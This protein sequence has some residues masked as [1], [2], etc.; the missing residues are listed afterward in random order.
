MQAIQLHITDR[1]RESLSIIAGLDD[2][3]WSEGD[4][5]DADTILDNPR[6]SLYCLDHEHQWTIFVV[7]SEALDLS[8]VPFVYQAQ[9]DYA[10]SLIAVPYP[11]FHQLANTIDISE[12]QLICIHNV[13]R[14]GSTLL[15][16]AFNQ[17]EDV[18]A[19][20][21]PDV[22]ANFITI[23]HT[24]RDQQIRLLQ[25]SFK[26]MFRPQA[27]GQ[28][29]HYVLKL[30]N[31]CVDIMDIFAE[32]FPDAKHIFMYRNA[33]DWLASLYGYRVRNQRQE[34]HFTRQQA[35]ERQMSYLN[36]PASDLEGFFTMAEDYSGTTYLA[37]S[38]LIMMRRFMEIYESGFQVPAIRYEDLN[39]DPEVVLKQV[40]DHLGLP[41]HQ[42]K[43]SLRAFDRDSQADTK[44]ARKETQS[45]N[46]IHL[47]NTELQA[48]EYIFASQANISPD[49]IVPNTLITN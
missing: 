29:Q 45:G 15:A 12:N 32:A 47:P 41:I 48:V 24:P 44:L 31:Q 49:M 38:W 7:L 16:Q 30:R 9:L 21:E 5:I 6:V 23:R 37:M 42:V 4:A 8:T 39:N 46:K 28:S 22:F 40:F 13:G 10:E 27:V 19:L 18:V 33:I 3:I 35:L 14:C 36:R 20:S 34:R 25:S 11:L 1:N 26:W 17:V 43:P 2:F